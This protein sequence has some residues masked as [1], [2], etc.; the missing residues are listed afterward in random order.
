MFL[1]T[2]LVGDKGERPNGEKLPLRDVETSVSVRYDGGRE[3]LVVFWAGGGCQA[4][5]VGSRFGV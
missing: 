3:S 5:V 1:A 4:L 2:C